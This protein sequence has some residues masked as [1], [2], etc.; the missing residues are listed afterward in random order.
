VYGLTDLKPQANV[1]FTRIAQDISEVSKGKLILKTAAPYSTL[2][3]YIGNNSLYFSG[4]AYDIDYYYPEYNF[5]RISTY[6]LPRITQYGLFSNISKSRNQTT[7]GVI[8]NLDFTLTYPETQA[9]LKS[10]NCKVVLEDLF[11][12]EYIVDNLCQTDWRQTVINASTDD[13]L[14]SD[15][16]QIN[17]STILTYNGTL[18]S[19]KQ[20]I[21]HYANTQYN[22]TTNLQGKADF[23]ITAEYSYNKIDVEFLGDNQY[24]GCSKTLLVST[25]NSRMKTLLTFILPALLVFLVTAYGAYKMLKFAGW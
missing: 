12:K 5:L 13:Q 3:F 2:K 18:L 25:S 8:T 10:R 22:K 1:T 7:G 9:V 24:L 14:Y 6:S 23:A 19:N 21:V 20:I 11:Q 15:G 17:I 16:Q 4:N